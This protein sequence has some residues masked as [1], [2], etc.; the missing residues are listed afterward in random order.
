MEYQIFFY[1]FCCPV[2]NALHTLHPL[3][4]IC[5]FQFFSNTLLHI[6]LPKVFL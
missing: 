4:L 5:G 6:I 3:H 2:M 1:D